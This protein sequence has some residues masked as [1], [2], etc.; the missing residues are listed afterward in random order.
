VISE[1]I[2]RMGGSCSLIFNSIGVFEKIHIGGGKQLSGGVE[3]YCYGDHRVCA[4]NVVASLGAKEASTIHGTKK[5]NDGFPEF[6]ETLKSL[7]ANIQ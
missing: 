3:L 7:G 6:I 5:L 4:A 2:R 1:N